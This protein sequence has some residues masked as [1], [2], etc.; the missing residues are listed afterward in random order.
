MTTLQVLILCVHVV[1]KGLT[2]QCTPDKV[3]KGLCLV[4]QPEKM[5]HYKLYIISNFHYYMY[6]LA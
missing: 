2:T 5:F 4:T 3:R 1:L 6:I